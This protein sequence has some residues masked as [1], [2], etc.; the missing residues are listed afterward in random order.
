M[1]LPQFLN[2]QSSIFGTNNHYRM[3]I[4][5]IAIVK[6]FWVDMRHLTYF[7]PNVN[8]KMEEFVWDEYQM[9]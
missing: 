4:A 6:Y 1:C 9:N 8:F 2:G 3:K 7:S 5:Y